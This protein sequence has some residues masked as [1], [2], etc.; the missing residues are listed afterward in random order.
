L[1]NRQWL[2]EKR[3]L[4]GEILGAGN[5]R[6]TQSE[7]P[8]PQAGEF[9]VRTIALGTSPAQ[10][11]YISETP[12]MHDKVP[13]GEVMRGRG[14]AEVVESQHPD[15]APGDLV[16]ASTGWQDY[17]VQRPRDDYVFGVRKVRHAVRPYTTAL[18]VLGN[19]G[20]TA[21]VG[22]HRIAKMQAGETVLISAAAGGVG[23]V[24]G[25]MARLRNAGTVVG[26][27]GTPEKC[28]WLVEDLGFNAAI[29][30]RSDNIAD[31][32]DEYCPGGVDVFFDNVGGSTLD[33][34]LS[35]IATGARIA[36]CGFIS[37]DYTLT[38]SQGPA[39]Y[40]NLL[41]RRARMEG[42]VVFDYWAQYAEAEDELAAWYRE[43]SLVNCEDVIEGL[44]SMPD[45]LAGLFSG[46]NKGVRLCR[47]AADPGT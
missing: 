19:A 16:V 26:I 45:A 4:A 34:V 42:F 8:A 43:G 38:G 20:V 14:V 5:F 3:P 23:S 7:V 31:A 22:L 28:R 6:Y 36:I 40:R 35:R 1:I 47:V 18:G 15:Y 11:G 2:L 10:R 9:L 46:D 41:T 27:A 44:E 25:Q 30:Y 29:N 39:N 32:L 33:T 21:W 17:S 37:T 13:I 12:S 24:A